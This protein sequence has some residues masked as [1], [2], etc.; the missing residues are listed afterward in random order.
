MNSGSKIVIG[1]REDIFEMEKLGYKFRGRKRNPK[2]TPRTTFSDKA[3][4]LRFEV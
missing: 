4:D 1:C 2:F 3:T